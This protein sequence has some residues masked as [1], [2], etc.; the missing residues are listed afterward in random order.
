MSSSRLASVKARQ[1]TISMAEFLVGDDDGLPRQ[2]L[3]AEEMRKGARLVKENKEIE[4][5]GK[6]VD[7]KSVTLAD[8][9][10]AARK[11]RE[12]GRMRRLS[13]DSI[14]SNESFCSN[15]S[16]L[17][18]SR[19][20]SARSSITSMSSD[21]IERWEALPLAEGK[22]VAT[23]V[24][25]QR[26]TLRTM[27]NLDAPLG[28]PPVLKEGT[29][30]LVLE[31]QTLEDGTQRALISRQ[32][33]HEALGWVTR[34]MT[35]GTVGLVSRAT[36]F[37]ERL[38]RSQK[39]EGSEGDRLRDAAEKRRAARRIPAQRHRPTRAGHSP[40]GRPQRH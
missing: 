21:T 17:P 23:L 2:R 11:K 22:A 12:E 24:S 6:V 35:D 27:P 37:K 15:A 39:G 25:T 1:K 8:V 13:K 3:S 16:S 40:H 10:A 38:A 9:R 20:S 36:A 28:K 4:E 34:V 32:G 33:Q 14:V 26:L 29:A 19:L 31:E 7:G 5:V 18:S 30:V